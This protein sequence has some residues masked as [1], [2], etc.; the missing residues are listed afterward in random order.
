MTNRK[1]IE[2]NIVQTVLSYSDQITFFGIGGVVRAVISAVA[3][4]IDELFYDVN[5]TQK[6]M[7]I[8]SA[9]DDDLD[10][11]ARDYNMEKLAAA[12]AG[13]VLAFQGTALTVIP[14]DTEVKSTSGVIF[15]TIEAITLG[16]NSPYDL[17][18]CEPLS[19]IVEA[20]A[21]TTGEAGNVAA[22][23][24]TTLVNAIVGVDS[25]TNPTHA[26]NGCDAEPD[27]Q[28]RTRIVER[29]TLLNQGSVAFYEAIV[30]EINSDVLRVFAT[31]GDTAREVA[32]YVANRSGT[33]LTAAQRDELEASLKNYA[34]ICATPKVYNISFTDIDIYAKIS[35]ETGYTLQDV[36]ENI[37]KNLADFLDWSALDF[38]IEL[39]DAD[40]VSIVN[41]SE[42]VK[43]ID[44][45]TFR[46]DSN[47][48]CANNSV[49]RLGFVY[50]ENMNDSTDTINIQPAT[51]YIYK[52]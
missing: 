51:T 43:D 35:L 7:F 8:I 49:P 40:I 50:V 32:I 24:I 16:N 38:G 26:Q 6:K 9:E 20:V 25:V 4:A 45:T 44:L 10:D 39:D 22:N 21:T 2:K 29:I 52:Y 48:K 30:K 36:F 13:V 15:K 23:T 17:Y 42:G 18:P 31:R 37:S 19:D 5:Q 47:T 12:A 28:F 3:A 33:G 46:P 27:N 11:L 1:T 14:A 41:N 34:P